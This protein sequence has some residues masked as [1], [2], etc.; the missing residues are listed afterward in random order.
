MAAAAAGVLTA[1]MASYHA[2]ME[3]TVP[4]S[5]TGLQVPSCGL[6]PTSPYLLKV[7]AR[8]IG[9]AVLPDDDEPCT[10]PSMVLWER[11]ILSTDLICRIHAVLRL[12]HNHQLPIRWYARRGA[13]PA[14]DQHGMLRTTTRSNCGLPSQMRIRTPC[15]KDDPVMAACDISWYVGAAG[16]MVYQVQV[17]HLIIAG[18]YNAQPTST[19][20]EPNAGPRPHRATFCGPQWHVNFQATRR[21]GF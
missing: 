17:N 1:A 13:A 16:E 20:W 11:M 14:I 19:R 8:D 5:I 7:E 12:F 9:L 2:H 18:R 6:G 10:Q 15:M 4:G 21:M 3:A